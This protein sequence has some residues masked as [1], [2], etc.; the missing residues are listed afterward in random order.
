MCFR[1]SVCSVRERARACAS[2]PTQPAARAPLPAARSFIDHINQAR[3]LTARAIWSV[4]GLVVVQAGLR[5]VRG[6]KLGDRCQQRSARGQA[7]RA[8]ACVCVRACVR[9]RACVY[10]CLRS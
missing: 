10:A 7:R 5:A 2:G 8:G 6:A 1:M 3:E 9:V 4:V